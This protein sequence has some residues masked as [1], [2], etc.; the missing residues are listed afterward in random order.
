MARR[1]R[2]AVGAWRF[3]LGVG[4]YAAGDT[5]CAANQTPHN[6][7]PDFESFGR[8]IEFYQDPLKARDLR[9][10]VRDIEAPVYLTGA[11]QDEQ[12]GAEFHTMVD[13]F[14]RARALRVALWNGRHPDGYAPSNLVRW[15]E[16][17]EFYVAERVPKLHPVIRAAAPA[18]L[19]SSFGLRDTKFENDRWPIFFG[20]D[21][22]AALP[23][24][25]ASARCG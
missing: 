2:A 5:T 8:A 17:L 18:I 19:A 13:H 22:Q 4:T 10:L 16:F 25:N 12:T 1:A 11:F 7:N 3:Q 6:V 21:Y 9:E 20:T 23:R 14:D 24:T 15:F